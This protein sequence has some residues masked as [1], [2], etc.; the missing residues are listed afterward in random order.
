TRKQWSTTIIS[1]L[2]TPKTDVQS[3]LKYQSEIFG[4]NTF[5]KIVYASA[6]PYEYPGL[7][8]WTRRTR[9]HSLHCTAPAGAC[10]TLRTPCR[11]ILA[12][13]GLVLPGRS[14]AEWRPG[15]RKA[16]RHL[17][18]IPASLRRAGPREL[19]VQESDE[20]ALLGY[21]KD[22]GPWAGPPATP[23]RPGRLNPPLPAPARPPGP[24]AAWAGAGAGAG[25][26]AAGTTSLGAAQR[27]GQTLPALLS[28]LVAALVQL[29]PSMTPSSVIPG[30]A[31]AALAAAALLLLAAP[32]AAAPA[33]A[34]STTSTAAPAPAPPQPEITPLQ[35]GE[36]F[37]DQRQ[38]GSEN[39]RIHMDGMV[40]VVAPP[41]A[42]M[43]V[44]GAAGAAG[45]GQGGQL[46]QQLLDIVAQQQAAGVED[47]D[48]K[49]GK[50][51]AKPPQNCV[52]GT[53]GCKKRRPGSLP[54]KS[55]SQL[56]LA[57][58]LLP[59]LRRQQVHQS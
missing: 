34:S 17:P 18:V 31:R 26:G 12:Q 57:S 15:L 48:V 16:G 39:Y 58:L 7:V 27:S 54:A 36:E 47:N 59:L 30:V 6:S 43:S 33:A 50:P 40:V 2:P 56:H 53:P 11:G 10:R 13:G 14:H 25:A 52:E 24:A 44:A 38:N 1:S 29:S 55:R 46:E 41:E 19:Q 23:L 32:A 51:G 28:A 49:P 4:K 3:S 35:P 21:A 42:L 5:R 8:F 37:Y 45:G 22:G 20:P 9:L